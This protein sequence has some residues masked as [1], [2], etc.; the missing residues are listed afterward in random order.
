MIN[1]NKIPEDEEIVPG[2]FASDVAE[3]A[4]K[5]FNWTDGNRPQKNSSGNG[6]LDILENAKPDISAS[7]VFIRKVVL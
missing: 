6:F 4:E 7:P 5:V 2:L 1:E 3:M